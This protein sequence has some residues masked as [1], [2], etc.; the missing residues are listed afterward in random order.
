MKVIINPKL[1]CKYVIF[2]NNYI[3]NWESKPSS[4]IFVITRRNSFSI[5]CY[6]HLSQISIQ[7]AMLCFDYWI[8]GKYIYVWEYDLIR[9]DDYKLNIN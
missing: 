5:V 4:V 2:V 9:K 1:I 6:F 8:S 7:F 3:C